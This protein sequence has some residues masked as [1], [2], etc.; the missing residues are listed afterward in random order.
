MAVDV[1]HELGGVRC[2]MGRHTFAACLLLALATAGSRTALAEPAACPELV[3]N[4]TDCAPALPDSLTAPVG[5]VVADV[6]LSNGTQVW[7]CSGGKWAFYDASHTLVR[8]LPDGG[9]ELAGYFNVRDPDGARPMPTITFTDP[10]NTTVLGSIGLDRT[11]AVEFSPGNG[12]DGPWYR[13]QL[14]DQ[15]GDAYCALAFAVRSET[16][17]GAPDASCTE[18]GATDSVCYVALGGRASCLQATIHAVKTMGDD[19]SGSYSNI[20]AGM[21][22]VVQHVRKNG[23]RGVVNMSLGGSFPAPSCFG[24]RST[25]LNDAAQQLINAGIPVVTSA[26]NKYGADA[27]TQSPAS[28]PQ[29]IAVASS[30]QK[31]ALSSFSNV[32]VLD[33]WVKGSVLFNGAVYLEDTLNRR[34]SRWLTLDGAAKCGATVLAGPTDGGWYH[35]QIN[36]VKLSDATGTKLTGVPSMWNKISILDKSGV[37]SGTGFTLQMDTAF[38]YS[39]DS[40]SFSTSAAPGCSCSPG[41][42]DGFS[43]CVSGGWVQEVSCVVKLLEW[44]QP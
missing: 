20:I 25:A 18:E 40:F 3:L 34:Q 14:V 4:A 13:R 30:D 42:L 22:W 11:S 39:S 2:R 9:E 6:L 35:V 24:P 26:G 38:L 10:D 17:G 5:S 7:K 28:N 8:P 21:N 29:S 32:G 31:D 23:W 1:D 19:G 37:C 43:V 41:Q 27:C 36:F 12:V 16:K 15:A 33:A 44:H